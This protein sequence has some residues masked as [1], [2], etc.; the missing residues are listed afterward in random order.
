M[1]PDLLLAFF[2]LLKANILYANIFKDGKGTFVLLK[3]IFFFSFVRLYGSWIYYSVSVGNSW[4]KPDVV[5]GILII[6]GQDVFF[7]T[8]C[9][10]LLHGDRP[11]WRG[12]AEFKGGWRYLASSFRIAANSAILVHGPGRLMIMTVITLIPYVRRCWNKFRC[13]LSVE[14][15]HLRA[16]S[17][18][19]YPM[20]KIQKPN[21]S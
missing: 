19:R 10:R 9:A 21:F 11:S 6:E 15:I 14:G 20:L 2:F 13:L 12:F 5:K 16:G 1:W 4:L 8:Y 18:R 3:F 7:G 17:P